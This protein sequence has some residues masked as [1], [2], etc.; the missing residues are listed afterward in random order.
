MS[1][2]RTHD[3]RESHDVAK[4]VGQDR[5][6]DA[7]CADVQEG[8]MEAKEGGVDELEDFSLHRSERRERGEGV[9]RRRVRERWGGCTENTKRGTSQSF[10][11]TRV[12]RSRR[13]RF[14]HLVLSQYRFPLLTFQRSRPRRRLMMLSLPCLIHTHTH[15]TS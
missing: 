8:G 7:T 10:L 12:K 1:T 14:D 3:I 11:L 15:A 4:D 13:V 6:E 2:D 9:D 5:W